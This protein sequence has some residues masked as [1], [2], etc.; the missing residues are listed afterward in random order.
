MNYLVTAKSGLKVRSG[1]GTDYE[2]A[3][4][5]LLYEDV[6]IAADQDSPDPAWLPI[7]LEDD[8]V[9][10]VARQYVEPVQ[11]D[12]QAQEAAKIQEPAPG[13]AETRVPIMQNQL[14]AL[15]GYPKENAGYLKIID[16]RDFSGS[17]T[18]V[19]DFQGNKWSCRVWGHEAMEAPL[20]EAFRLLCDQGL[21]GE[22]RTYDG[23]FNI[24]K[25]TSGRSYSV[26]SW[27]M[28]VDLN[29]GTNGYKRDPSLSPDFVQC[30]TDA[31][32][33]WGGDWQ[34][35]DGMH[36]QICHTR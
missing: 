1:P 25:M 30:F 27:G 17:L 32:F 28:A 10:F 6:I 29:A 24:R 31:G 11:T 5:R 12:Y 2:E 33:E 4:E 7:L 19:R 21:A 16:L 26:H 3:A 18:H 22:L 9:G 36:F 14:T 23:C 15:Y 13:L 8:T 35:P 34:T 20:K